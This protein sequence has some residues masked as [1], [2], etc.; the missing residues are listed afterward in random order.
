M[1]D[2]FF[3]VCTVAMAYQPYR[4]HH[5]PGVARL[6]NGDLLAVWG[7]TGWLQVGPFVSARIA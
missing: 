2:P 3:E 1:T 7:A 4:W 5:D 6:P